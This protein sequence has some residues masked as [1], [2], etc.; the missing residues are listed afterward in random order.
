MFAH[1][2]MRAASGVSSGTDG[3]DAYTTLLIHSDTTNGDTV[4][5]DSSASAHSI[6]ANDSTQH[7]TIE[8]YFGTTSIKF[9][10]SSDY[11][12]I[13]NHTDFNFGSD[14]FTID[15]WFK[16][17]V[18]ASWKKFL[19]IGVGG[20]RGMLMQIDGATT[21]MM[22]NIT[23]AAGTSWGVLSSIPM[24]FPGTWMHIAMIRTGNTIKI[25]KNGT[26]VG[27]DYSI[28]WS[29][30]M[31]TSGIQIGGVSDWNS[32]P[33]CYMDEFRI[34]KGIAR[35]TENFTPPTTPYS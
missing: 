15:F 6:T 13:P 19:G 12:R 14:D 34:S 24:G 23:N 20:Y 7:S 16:I 18:A 4:F 22:I 33:D 29:I 30:Q 31:T 2:V 21:N 1:G 9:D 5:T 17:N 26:Q 10:G 32:Y 27:S 25:F 35:W 8:K 28:T 11:L 3:N